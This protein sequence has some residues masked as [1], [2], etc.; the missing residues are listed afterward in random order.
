MP[1]PPAAIRDQ[2]T[3]LDVLDREILQ[4][5][6]RRQ[7]VFGGAAALALLPAVVREPPTRVPTADGVDC[8]VLAVPGATVAAAG[9]GA[10]AG[11]AAPADGEVRRDTAVEGRCEGHRDQRPQ[12]GQAGADDGHVRLERQ[13]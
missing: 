10:F 13:P 9:P 8:C 12:D 1:G 4:R 7:S 6:E 5:V 2:A 3:S 11:Y